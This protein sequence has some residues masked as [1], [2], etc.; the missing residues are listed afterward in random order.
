MTPE[1]RTAYIGLDSTNPSALN[2]YLGQVVGLMPA[3]ASTSGH[4]AWRADGKR[5]RVW[6]Q[7]G[8]RDD[9]AC[10]GFEATSQQAYDRALDRL[11]EA[12]M[13]VLP[14]DAAR[15][16]ARG[17]VDGVTMQSPWQVPIELVLGLADAG[18]PFASPHFPDGI[19][20]GEQGFGHA[21]FVVGSQ[22]E[23]DA[24]RRFAEALGL[25][26]TDWLRMALGPAGAPEMHVSFMHC[27]A[28]HHSLALAFVPMPAVP[29]RLHHINFEVTRV[30]D[31]G[32]AFERA[33]AHGTP[34][35]NTIGQHDNDGMVSFYSVS[36]GGWRVEVGATGRT[37]GDDWDD[38]REYNR[39]STWGHQ[40]PEAFAAHVAAPL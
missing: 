13:S 26:L 25:H 40:P 19:V 36:P 4:T 38:V 30:D 33:M 18:T 28:R 23:Y 34:L 6:V 10:L 29:Q 12:G 20:T 14:F 15:R 2:D 39:I 21:V 27:N 22:E 31:V 7:P 32:R 11:A 3:E 5:Q 35:A 16:K 24:S 1:I 37:V 17:V 8:E 9:A